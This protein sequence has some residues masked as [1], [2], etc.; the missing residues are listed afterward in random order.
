MDKITDKGRHPFAPLY[1]IEEVADGVAFYKGFSNLG[2]V[3]TDDGLVLIDTGS[4]H[5]VAQGRIFEKV[6]S[7]SA[8]PIRTAIYTHGHADHAYGLPPFLAEAKE[9]GWP[10]PEII[11]HKL[12][13]DRMDR[14]I[15]TA[16]F[17]SAINTRQFGQEQGWPTDPIY[18]TRT[19]EATLD[20]EV[21]GVG[22]ELHHARGETDDHTWLFLPKQK[23]VYTGD[24]FIWAVPN[25]GN[26]AKVQRYALDWIEA[27][28]EMSGLGAEVLLCGHGLPVFGADR[29]RQALSET[30]DYLQS[31]LDQTLG[32]MNKG[33]PLDAI[34]RAVQP[35]RELADRPYLQ[36]IYDEPEFIV[37]NIWRYYG[38][39]Y[40]DR[41]SDLKPASTASLANEVA[42]LA[43]SVDHLIKRAMEHLA[44]SETR[45][46]C[47]LIDWAAEAD[48]DSREV[49]AA[50]AA[51][52]KQRNNTETSTMAKGIFRAAS[53][54]S[55]AK[56]ESD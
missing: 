25:A 52:Y 32:L 42:Q 49:H 46:A 13:R 20:L 53:V 15:L 44:A 51:I 28:R 21:G 12:I 8:E 33:A 39:W 38:G 11:G 5:P 7:W 48:P 47:H 18:P 2:A 29:V 4:F 6:R 56:S 10:K 23:V 41:P 9:K 26:P 31:L 14:Y 50:R 37:R 24:L 22:F 36:P 45:L 16:D 1:H 43:G 19:Y 35:P 55:Q 34:T 54:E 40:N 30:A 27:L 3:S 17:N